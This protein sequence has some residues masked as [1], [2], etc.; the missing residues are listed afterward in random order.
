MA[1]VAP[2][3]STTVRTNI[4]LGLLR[5]GFRLGGWIAPD[6]TA[7]RAGRLF[8]TPLVP[9][10]RRAQRA[11]Q[12]GARRGQL[13][14]GDTALTTYAWGNPGS[15]P[16]ILFSHGWS[17]HG[18]RVVAWLPA[19]R[20]AG[21]A[22]VA[23]DQQ[24]HGLSPGS[25]AALPD[26]VRGLQRVGEHFGP[27]HAVLGHSLGGAAAMLALEAGLQARLALLVAPAADAVSAS[28]RFAGFVGLSRKVQQRMLG[29]FEAEY[30][31][32]FA[33]MQVHAVAPRLAQPALVLHDLEDR[34]V[35]WHEGEA[36]ARHWPDA[37]LLSTQGLGHRRIL[38]APDVIDA[39]LRFLNGDIVGERVVSSP[40]LP[41]GLA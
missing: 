10:R 32:R 24:G 37:R 35:P 28:D 34:E 6:S 39:G 29:Q 13:G 19:L 15:E 11:T 16:Y 25:F 8:G 33:A 2:N 27:A 12:A 9:A 40:N 41:F 30:R 38:D 26:F 18:T 22:V 7:R 4:Q 17:S 36:Y 14:S 5:A 21:F 3:F 31:I 20:R 23:F 1:A